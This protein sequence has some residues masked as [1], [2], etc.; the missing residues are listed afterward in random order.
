MGV[1]GTSEFDL[2]PLHVE[3]RVGQSTETQQPII[4]DG[5]STWQCSGIAE[6]GNA[7]SVVA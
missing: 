6:H 1:S 2:W 4:D 3:V 5:S 7:A